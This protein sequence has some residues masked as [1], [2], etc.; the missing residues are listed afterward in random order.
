MSR[1]EKPAGDDSFRKATTAEQQTL[2]E[3]CYG[4]AGNTRSTP[5]FNEEALLHRKR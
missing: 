4:A 2:A 3:V 5:S 1:N